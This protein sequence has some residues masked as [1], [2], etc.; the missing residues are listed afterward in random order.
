MSFQIKRYLI[1]HCSSFLL[2]LDSSKAFSPKGQSKLLEWVFGGSLSVGSSIFPGEVMGK[3]GALLLSAGYSGLPEEKVVQTNAFWLVIVVRDSPLD[4]VMLQG[5]NKAPI[6]TSYAGHTG[7]R[8]G[9][10]LLFL[11]GKQFSACCRSR[12]ALI[13][14]LL[15]YCWLRRGRLSTKWCKW[16]VK[17]K[18]WKEK[19]GKKK[20]SPK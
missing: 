15:P 9:C 8:G 7:R 4:F 1:T 6:E 14:Y 18:I 11:L 20:K 19:E 3:L 13:Y 2:Y 10:R 17:N 5:E 12:T 16:A